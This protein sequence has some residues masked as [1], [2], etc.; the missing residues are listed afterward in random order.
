MEGKKIEG[1]FGKVNIIWPTEVLLYLSIT[2]PVTYF[3]SLSRIP[4]A[5]AITASWEIDCRNIQKIGTGTIEGRETWQE[6]KQVRPVQRSSDYSFLSV[7]DV[8]YITHITNQLFI[9]LDSD[10]LENQSTSYSMLRS[11][12]HGS[13]QPVARNG[14][15]VDSEARATRESCSFRELC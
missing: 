11:S 7:P 6:K 15:T 9:N 5:A 14:A 8:S 2:F 4:N 12:V 3:L 13:N 1:L 10:I